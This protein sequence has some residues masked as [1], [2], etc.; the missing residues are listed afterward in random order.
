MKPRIFSDGISGTPNAAGDFGVGQVSRIR[1]AVGGGSPIVN[2]VTL[3]WDRNGNKTAR[4]DAIFAPAIPRTNSLSLQYDGL[5]RLT[6]ATVTS[7]SAV[8]RDTVYG[9]ARLSNR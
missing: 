2:E 4:A 5:D 3:A 1:H 9:L 7:G 8:V 6:R